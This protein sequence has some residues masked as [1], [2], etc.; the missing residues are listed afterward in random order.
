VLDTRRSR[1][2]QAVWKD[3][4]RVARAFRLKANVA[5][6]SARKSF[7]VKEYQKG[8]LKRLQGLLCHS[9]EAVTML[10]AF[11]DELTARKLRRK[12]RP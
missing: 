11:A 2:R 8:G 7:A 1:T 12:S 10:Y 4:K 3:L 6:H 5:P 9:D